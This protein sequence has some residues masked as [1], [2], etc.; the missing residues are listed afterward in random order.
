MNKGEGRGWV[1]MMMM[2]CILQPDDDDEDAWY[3]VCFGKYTSGR[4]VRQ[5]QQLLQPEDN[6]LASMDQVN[7]LVVMFQK[8]AQAPNLCRKVPVTSGEGG[9]V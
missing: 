7:A 4:D 2:S 3:R 5:H 1:M 8:L 6:V 9:G